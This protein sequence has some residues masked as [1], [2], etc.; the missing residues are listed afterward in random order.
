M[1]YKYKQP[2]NMT[3]EEMEDFAKNPT[4]WFEDQ[5]KIMTNHDPLLNACYYTYLSLH[6][7]AHDPFEQVDFLIFLAYQA[8]LSNSINFEQL[9]KVSQRIVIPMPSMS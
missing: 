9:V 1:K 4:K 6:D 7:I 5:L 8:L 2:F 3:A